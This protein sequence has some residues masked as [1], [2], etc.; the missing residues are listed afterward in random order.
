MTA[1]LDL[2]DV[3]LVAVF[4][5]AHDLT[6][7]AVDDCLRQAKFGDVKLFT[8]RDVGREAVRAG[9][10]ASLDEAGRFSTY[11]LPRHIDTSHI[12]SIHWDSWIV[13]PEMWRDEYLQYDYVGAPWWYRDAYNVGNSGFCLRSKRLMDYIAANEAEF[14]MLMPEDLALCRVYQPRLPQFRWAPPAL[15][16][17]FAFERTRVTAKSFGFHGMFLWPDVL[18]DAEIEH[19][20]K[21]ATPYVVESGHYREM[22]EIMKRRGPNPRI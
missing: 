3:T 4:T 7:M 21:F 2:P 22:R 13:Q 6:L 12:L 14:P 10:F 15:A 5:V 17:L 20:M 11:T 16:H 8:D 1:T 18:T 9:P 19:R